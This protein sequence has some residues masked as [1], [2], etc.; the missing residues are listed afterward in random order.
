MRAYLVLGIIIDFVLSWKA[1]ISKHTCNE[2][3]DSIDHPWGSDP[4]ETLVS[5]MWNSKSNCSDLMPEIT[6]A[7]PQLILKGGSHIGPCWTATDK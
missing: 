6:I 1:L 2:E 3:H 7:T 5:R 4:R